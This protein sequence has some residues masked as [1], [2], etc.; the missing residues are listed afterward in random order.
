MNN[1][2]LNTEIKEFLKFPDEFWNYIKNRIIYIDSSISDSEFFYNTLMKF[3]RENKLIDIKVIVPYAID[4][5]TTLV[6]IHEFKHA[7]D[8]YLN[9]GKTIDNEEK[10]EDSA[11]EMEKEFVKK[12]KK[13]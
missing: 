9:L 4:L 11:V 10:Y 12:Y 1:K 5:K 8:L 6:N 3:D 13:N 2:L 7:Y